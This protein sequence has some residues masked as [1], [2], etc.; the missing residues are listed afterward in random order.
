MKRIGKFSL[1]VTSV[2]AIVFLST[3][4]INGQGLLENHNA[5]PN[6]KISSQ[7]VNNLKVLWKVTS[8]QYITHKPL[9]QKDRGIFCRLGRNGLCRRCHFRQD[10]LAEDH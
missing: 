4:P 8:P 2:L 1:L 9:V 3:R 5:D 6:L 7:N 10:Y